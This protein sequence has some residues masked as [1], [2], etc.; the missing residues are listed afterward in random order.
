LAVFFTLIGYWR[1][2]FPGWQLG[3]IVAFFNL[4]LLLF[5]GFTGDQRLITGY[6]WAGSVSAITGSVVLVVMITDDLRRLL[7]RNNTQV[8]GRFVGR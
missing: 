4:N 8:V 7:S 5:Y 6:E 1:G 2:T 3:T